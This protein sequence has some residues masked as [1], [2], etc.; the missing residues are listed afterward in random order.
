MRGVSGEAVWVMAADEEMEVTMREDSQVRSIACG[1]GV[2]LP[3][4]LNLN[5]HTGKWYY[6]GLLKVLP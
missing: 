6:R 3:A 2:F 1:S 5:Q 4:Q